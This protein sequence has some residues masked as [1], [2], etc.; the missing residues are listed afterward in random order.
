[1]DAEITMTIY[2]VE[3]EDDKLEVTCVFERT[4]LARKFYRHITHDLT[5]TKVHI[6]GN[7]KFPLTIIF[8]FNLL[9]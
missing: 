9:F 8:S 6:E 4:S 3:N 1:M 2:P 5:N 7:R